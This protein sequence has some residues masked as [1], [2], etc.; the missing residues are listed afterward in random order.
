MSVSQFL[1]KHDW[2]V[3]VQDGGTYL[4]SGNQ[5]SNEDKN[6]SEKVETLEN[7]L[8]C[9]KENLKHELEKRKED[10]SKCETQLKTLVNEIENGDSDEGEDDDGL[11]GECKSET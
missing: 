4:V 11:D 7:Q 1:G 2:K 6:V 3:S 8:K 9:W 10:V 5:T